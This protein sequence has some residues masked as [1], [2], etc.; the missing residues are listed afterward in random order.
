MNKILWLK[1]MRDLCHKNKIRFRVNGKQYILTRLQEVS[2][3]LYKT[4]IEKLSPREKEILNRKVRFVHS[5][6]F[7]LIL[8]WMQKYVKLI[9]KLHNKNKNNVQD[10]VIYIYLN[11]ETRFYICKQLPQGHKLILLFSFQKKQVF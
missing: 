1:T 7:H 4:A 2:I 8:I 6:M 9:R 3:G 5:I 10:Y 11:F